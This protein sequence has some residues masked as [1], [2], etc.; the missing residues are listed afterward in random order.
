MIISVILTNQLS[1]YIPIVALLHNNIYIYIYIYN[2]DASVRYVRHWYCW[3]VNISRL[4]YICWG[5]HDTIVYII[6]SIF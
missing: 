4:R 2:L 1:Y 3:L 5:I 6:R